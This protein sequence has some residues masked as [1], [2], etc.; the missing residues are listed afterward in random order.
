MTIIQCHGDAYYLRI[1][2]SIAAVRLKCDP[3]CTNQKAPQK[4]FRYV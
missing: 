4:Y 3:V 2:L 1:L